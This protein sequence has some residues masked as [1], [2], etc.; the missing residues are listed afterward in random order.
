M[1]MIRL[2]MTKELEKEQDQND[3]D[4]LSDD[5]E[6]EDDIE[7]C[8]DDGDNEASQEEMMFTDLASDEGSDD[9][10]AASLDSS[11]VSNDSQANTV[12]VAPLA[13]STQ[14]VDE[15]D[16]CSLPLDEG[17][18]GPEVHLGG[19]TPTCPEGQ[20]KGVRFSEGVDLLEERK[21][22]RQERGGDRPL[23]QKH[24]Q[25][26]ALKKMAS[27]RSGKSR[28]YWSEILRGIFEK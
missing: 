7:A 23:L 5:S 22:R 14:G 24:P 2:E 3:D 16:T 8:D 11:D 10:T 12:N 9:P 15:V 25:K 1:E 26:P 20:K 13:E 21:A 27:Q 28:S 18:L 17:D 19:P 6:N 4:D